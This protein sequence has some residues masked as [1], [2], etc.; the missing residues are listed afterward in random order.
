MKC[1]VIGAG[2]A[3]A[4]AAC[5]LQQ[6]GHDVTVFEASRHLGGR[7]RSNYSPKLEFTVD[8]G[9]HILLGAYSGILTLMQALGIEPEERL[10][11]DDLAIRSADCTLELRTAP[12]PAPWH[13]LWGVLS[14]KGLSLSEKWQLLRLCTQLQWQ[15][16][17]VPVGQTVLQWLQQ[18]KQSERLVRIFWQPL[19]VAAMNT[20][21]EIA[22]AQLFA[23][24]LRDSLGASRQASQSLIPLSGLSEL[25]CHTALAHTDL[26]LG[27]RVRLIEQNSDGSYLVNGE[28]YHSAIVCAQAP[29]TASLLQTLPSSPQSITLLHDLNAMQHIP[30]ATV[31]LELASP[32]G[33]PHPMWLLQEDAQGL[34][35]GQWLFDHSCLRAGSTLLAI[36]ISDAGRLQHVDKEA[37]IR[38]IITQVQTQTAKWAHA[39]PEVCKSELIMEKRA[40]FAAVPGLKRPSN[41]SPW[42]GLYLAGDWTDTG[43]PGVLEGAVRS[44]LQ[45]ADLLLQQQSS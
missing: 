30:I 39:M 12:L 2:W 4:A 1:A 17:Q 16:W 3:G 35:A 32:W 40:S 28:R 9:Q 26:R 8:N 13:L 33:L 38:A 42:A 5:R 29:H 43:Y 14:A 37:V 36:V 20:P 11:R 7:A 15:K 22:C 41:L 18:G 25:W 27:S 6:A 21:I 44:G 19:C 10:R 23:H 34:A 45:A 24:V 31:Y